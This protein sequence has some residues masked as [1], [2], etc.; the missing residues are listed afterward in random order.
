MA[1]TRLTPVA[2]DLLQFSSLGFFFAIAVGPRVS[3]ENISSFGEATLSDIF[4]GISLFSFSLEDASF[5][6][7]ISSLISGSESL[8]FKMQELPLIVGDDL[9]AS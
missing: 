7:L 8:E 5:S 4:P 2:D 6:S 9:L 1:A 3:K